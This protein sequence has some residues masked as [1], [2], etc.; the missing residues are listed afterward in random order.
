MD[1]SFRTLP[2]FL[3]TTGIGLMMSTLVLVGFPGSALAEWYVA[4][5]GGLS[6]PDKLIDANMDTFGQR[7]A[8]QQFPGAAATPPVGT[9]TQ[10]FNT[11]DIGLK[12]SALVGGKAGY[13]FK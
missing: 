1:S 4:G 3:L 12:N 2:F 8:F 6:M 7:L 10:S 11:S 13:F 9:L 5:Y